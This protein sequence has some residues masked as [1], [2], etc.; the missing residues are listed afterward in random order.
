MVAYGEIRNKDQVGAT[1]ITTAARAPTDTD[2]SNGG[3][4]LDTSARVLYGP[5]L[6][7]SPPPADS[8]AIDPTTVP[9][10]YG[11]GSYT[12]GLKVRFL[13]P[14]AVTALRFYRRSD[15]LAVS[16]TLT[17]Y[18]AG[19]SVATAASSG[20]TG[21]GWKT[22]QLATPV[23]VDV[24]IDYVAAYSTGNQRYSETPGAVPASYSPSFITNLGSFY[25]AGNG[26]PSTASATNYYADLVFVANYRWLPAIKSAP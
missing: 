14:G 26:L 11:S 12:L 7:T 10:T 2:G 17:L 18:R 5:K 4:W 22:L 1:T 6:D 9:T 23:T 20:E 19:V 3:Y 15:T 8:Y 24:G 16:R 21:G 25:I 13:V